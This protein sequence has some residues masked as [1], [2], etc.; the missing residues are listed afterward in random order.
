MVTLCISSLP[1]CVKQPHY[2]GYAGLKADLFRSG[3]SKQVCEV[4]T[5]QEGRNQILI[6]DTKPLN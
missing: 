3:G 2:T 1:T 5:T 4:S 6:V